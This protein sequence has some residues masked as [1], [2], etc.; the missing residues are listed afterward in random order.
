MTNP[1]GKK[2]LGLLVV[3]LCLFLCAS[4]MV[5]KAAVTYG[6]DAQHRLIAVNYD[7]GASITYAYDSTGNRL[8]TVSVGP[9][10]M[11]YEDGE[12]GNI[13]G[14]DMTLQEPL[15]KICMTTY[16]RAGLSLLPVPVPPTV[17]G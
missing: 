9:S 1:F 15:S 8:S 10:Q 14:W 5:A 6:Y 3:C 16:V 12:D 13:D 7:N 4:P 11:A 17:I 2:H